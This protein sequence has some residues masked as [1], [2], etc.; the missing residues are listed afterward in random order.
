[1]HFL[2]GGEINAKCREKVERKILEECGIVI[3]RGVHSTLPSEQINW[4]FDTHPEERIIEII[5]K[6]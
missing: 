3:G 4:A 2:R 6:L 1:M 5:R